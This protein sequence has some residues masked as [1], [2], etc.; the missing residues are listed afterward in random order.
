MLGRLF[1]GESRAVS[2]QQVWGSGGDFGGQGTWAGTSVSQGSSLQLSAVYASVR[3]ICDSVS[4]FPAATFVR[5]NGARLPYYPKPAWI[6]EPDV[7]VTWGDYISQV[8]VSLLLDGNAFVQILRNGG[9]EVIA[10]SPISPA[11]VDVRRSRATR[12]PEYVIDG[13]QVVLDHT[14][15][16]HI[17]DIRRPGELRG[18]SRINELKQSL[19]LAKALDEFAARFFGNGSNA[20]GVIE[21][22]GNLTQEQAK[23]M[24]DTWEASHRGLGKSHRPAVIGGG[25]KWTKTTVDPENSQ[26]TESRRFAVE[27]IA[28]MFGLPPSLIGSTAP[29]S[30]SFASVEQQNLAFVTYTLRPL[31]T[32]LEVA[33]SR[34]LPGD[35]FLRL[36]MDA[37][38][39]GDSATQAQVFSTG[40]Q[41]GYLSV[42]DIR[43]LLDLRPVDGGDALR[44]PLANVNLSAAELSDSTLRVDM[45]AK[46]VQS[47]FDPAS[48]LAAMGL[49]AMNH[50]GLAS[51][52]LQPAQNA[53]V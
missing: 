32:N 19:G 52:Q 23:D 18:I 6:S 16:L 53:Q 8:V 40:I 39:R 14:D 28:R 37:L 5:Q 51:N 7:G 9:G 33:H 25:A 42:N 38:L 43:G 21:V 15:V 24:V 36:N 1:G 13:G 44:V 22:D 11:R 50:T 48:V 29:G 30:M 4:A 2:Y 20:G 17:V 10:L 12:L 27:D 41:A 49:P 45:A 46:L 3:L 31:V 26:L 35:V 47:G 34:L